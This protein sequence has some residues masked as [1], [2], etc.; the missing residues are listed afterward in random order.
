MVTT[1][2]GRTANDVFR[3]TAI[4]LLSDG[5]SNNPRGMETLELVDAW[6]TLEDPTESVVTMP[7]RNPNLEYLRGEMEWYKSGSL[8]A[9]DIAE[10]SK[11]WSKLADT[12]GTVNSNYGFLSMV[13]KWSG[14]SQLEWCIDSLKKDRNTRQAIINYNQPRHKYEGNKDFVCTISQQF[15]VR[16][17]KLDTVVLMRSNDLIFGLT[18]DMPWFSYLLQEVSKATDIPI[19]NYH[20]YASSLHVYKK[21]FKMLGD[22]AK[23]TNTPTSA[24]QLKL[25]L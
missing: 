11:F 9:K 15:V 2:R 8:F 14:K 7:E 10:H 22:I 12:N 13:E 1:I 4:K 3:N 18:Y 17:D 16:E 5:H 6:L 19:G 20:H 24:K 23:W 25:S 21:H